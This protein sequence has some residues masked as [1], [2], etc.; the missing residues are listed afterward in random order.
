MFPLKKFDWPNDYGQF[1]AIRKYDVHTGID[2]YCDE[3][4]EV[5]SIEDGIVISIEDFTGEKAGSPWWNDTKA[6]LIECYSGVVCYGEIEP[7]VSYGQ[8]IKAG[9][10]IGK[11]KRVLRVDKGRPT[12]MLHLELYKHGTTKTVWWRLG[13]EKPDE[14]LSPITLLK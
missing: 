9:Q 6:V 13:E 1:G 7:V 11:I 2:L 4:A 8:L 10:L 3:G 14:L 5:F 12:S